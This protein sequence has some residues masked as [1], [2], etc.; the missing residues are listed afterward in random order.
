[1]RPDHQDYQGTSMT[2][3]VAHRLHVPRMMLIVNKVPQQFDASEVKACV[4]QTYNAG[5]AAVVPRSDELM[6]LTRTGVFSLKYP[7]HSITEEWKHVVAK[8]FPEFN[9]H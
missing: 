4:E 8:L 3:E 2:V 9:N 5:V 7:D 1:M 6:S